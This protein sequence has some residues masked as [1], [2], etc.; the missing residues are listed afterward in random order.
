MQHS[1][2]YIPTTYE[3]SQEILK[4]NRIWQSIP[5]GRLGISSK[6]L[7]QT[8]I[9]KNSITEKIITNG[10]DTMI[11]KYK[12]VIEDDIKLSM[13]VADDIANSIFELSEAKLENEYKSKDHENSK[14][15]QRRTTDVTFAEISNHISLSK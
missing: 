13:V 1:F 14:R 12:S 8:I 4:L 9:L 2:P 15:M 11:K 7:K 3:Q 6:T 10:I 5:N